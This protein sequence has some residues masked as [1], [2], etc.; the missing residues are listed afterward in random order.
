MIGLVG[1]VALYGVALLMSRNRRAISPRLIAWG[2]GLQVILALVILKTP[3]GRAM[4][5]ALGAGVQALLVF[6][7]QGSLFVFGEAADPEGDLGYV[8]AFRVLPI[9]IFISSLF[10]VFYYLG[11]MQRIVLIMARA[12]HRLMGVSGAESLAAAA[13]VFMGQ[14]EAPIIVSPYIPAMTTSELMA[15][16]TSGMATVSGA[17]LASYIGLGVRPEYLLSASVM[18]APA[19]LVMAKLL[20][21]ETGESKTA[22]AVTIDVEPTDVN[23]IDAAARGAGQG[24]M[25]ALNIGGMLVAFVALIYLIDGV[26]AA[27]GGAFASATRLA[28]ALGLFAAMLGAY[29]LGWRPG[30]RGRN[31]TLGA[32]AVVA[33]VAVAVFLVR[34]PA[35]IA[36]GLRPILATLFAPVAF[37]MG[38]PWAESGAVGELFGIKLMLN[39]FVAYVEL[40]AL[41]R[42]GALSPKSELIASYALC[43]FANF[44][45]IGIQIGGIGSLAPTRRS[46]LASLGLRAVL[47]GTLATFTVATLAGLLTSF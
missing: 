42:E 18:A 38:V 10:S 6:A 2:L 9:V 11:V 32:G 23:I 17:V 36:L 5:E 43:G 27:V 25:L 22:G 13:N 15:L 19:S 7:D 21:P 47:G 31:L 37:V 46:D 44:A 12:M 29:L 35:P 24:I 3:W 20:I 16:M 30:P 39:E 8:F 40:S 28:V 4:F 41:L 1:L 26:L 45:S 34:G 33:V 14:T